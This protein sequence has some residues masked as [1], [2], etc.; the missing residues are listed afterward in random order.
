MIHVQTAGS[1]QFSYTCLFPIEDSRIHVNAN[2]QELHSASRH[3]FSNTSTTSGTNAGLTTVLGRQPLFQQ[4]S[5][6]EKEELK[7]ILADDV[8]KMKLLFGKLVTKTCDSFEERIPVVKFAAS[9][10]ALG[11]FDPAPEERGQS[12]LNEHREEI[13]RAESIPEIFIILSAY[14]NYLN[15]EILEYIVDLHGTSEDTE[16]L[17][18]YSEELHNFCKRRIFELPLSDNG[19]GTS[20]AL[21]PRQEEINVK[22]NVREDI[23]IEELQRIKGRIAKILC[24]KQAALM[25]HH[26]NVG[27]VQITFL[28][29]KFVARKIFPLSIEQTSAL[30]KDVSVI[31][32][33][34]GDYEFEVFEQYVHA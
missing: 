26:V 21:N 7:T 25:I 2:S 33:E 13:K 30:S 23:T 32:L 31:R 29:P 20:N 14:W 6:S 27:C 24:V 12:L 8:R 18:S 9:V 5:P 1:F 15:C 22:I 4:L 11:A 17:K 28:I 34:C 19:S 16:R 10:A 3:E